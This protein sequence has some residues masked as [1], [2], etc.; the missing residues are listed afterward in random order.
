[1]VRDAV[2]EAVWEH[3]RFHGVEGHV[4]VMKRQ[5]NRL[6]VRFGGPFC[7]SC[8]PEEYYVDLQLLLQKF[9]GRRVRIVSV[10]TE[11]EDSIVEFQ[12]GEAAKN[13]SKTIG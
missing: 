7:L 9:T 2:E 3:N 6:V 8:S 13:K 12:L 1:M 10:K 11:E 5:E 4:A